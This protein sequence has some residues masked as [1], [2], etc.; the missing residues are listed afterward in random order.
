LEKTYNEDMSL[1]DIAALAVAAINLKED[2]KDGAKNI[3]I[4][5][6]SHEKKVLE[7]ISDEELEKY[8][9]IAKQKFK[10]S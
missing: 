3:R 8:S 4:A 2:V 7:K 10:Q 6:I 9:Q 5:K 1:E